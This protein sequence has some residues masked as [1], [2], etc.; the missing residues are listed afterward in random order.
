VWERE[1]DGLRNAE[2]HLLL[3]LVSLCSLAGILQPF[4]EQIGLPAT[5]H[6]DLFA[7]RP[8]LLAFNYSSVFHLR[9][10]LDLSCAVSL[11][12]RQSNYLS[13]FS[14]S[15]IARC[16]GRAAF[17][18]FSHADWSSSPP[19]PRTLSSTTFPPQ[20]TFFRY[21]FWWTSIVNL[22]AFLAQARSV[23]RLRRPQSPARL[24]SN[25]RHVFISPPNPPRDPGHGSPVKSFPIF[26]RTRPPA[27][28]G[29]FWPSPH[30]IIQ[31]A[32][33]HHPSLRPVSRA[34]LH[35][36]RH[37]SF[38]PPLRRFPSSALDD[39]AITIRSRLKSTPNSPPTPLETLHFSAATNE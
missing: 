27:D 23:S 33:L 15:I 36:A 21:S 24:S 29:V 25:D 17:P 28:R 20:L 14:F 7:N 31:S 6:N 37:L 11:I 10:I 9:F 16:S 19:L 35:A 38:S 12:C 8:L 5:R 32:P 30:I 3:S 18:C 13:F 34:L 26:R 22:V 1:K 39:T 4:G 2:K